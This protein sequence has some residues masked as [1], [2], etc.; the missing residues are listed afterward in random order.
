[1]KANSALDLHLDKIYVGD[2]FETQ[3]QQEVLT[4]CDILRVLC[5]TRIKYQS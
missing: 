2:C 3:K 5:E 1:M 4:N